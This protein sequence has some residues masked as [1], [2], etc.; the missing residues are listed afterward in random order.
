MR[1]LYL[2]AILSIAVFS[3]KK[4]EPS[5]ESYTDSLTRPSSQLSAD[6]ARIIF[7]KRIKAQEDLFP[8]RQIQEKDK[9]YPVDEAPLDTIFFVFRE[10]LKD[11][12]REKD[13]FFLLDK[14]DENI[15]TGEQAQGLSAFAQKWGLTSETATMQSPLWEVLDRL[16]QSG[17]V[18]DEFRSQF[19]APYYFGTFPKE[20]A[21]AGAGVILGAGVRMRSAPNLNSK[22]EKKLN[23]DLVE[24]LE[25]T[26]EVTTISE[27]TFPWVKI[28]ARDQTEGYV[29]G[30]FVGRPL[31]D[32]LTFRKTAKGWKIVKL[33]T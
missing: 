14:I 13:I 22:I 33:I 1:F 9:L 32:Q 23:H 17:G 25:V 16:L 27:E 15:L 12:V 8:S 28:K 10:Q 20:A 26:S 30:K 19:H 6:S 3:C 24:I 21:S 18:F 31:K 7:Q 11:A 4:S 29:W 5:E 2:I